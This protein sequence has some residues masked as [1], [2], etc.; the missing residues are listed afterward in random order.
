MP[1]EETNIYHITFL[2]HGESVGNAGGYHQG[3]SEFSLTEKGRQQAE[4]LAIRWKTEGIR[5]DFMISSPQSRAKETAEIIAATLGLEIEFDPVWM[6]RDNGQLAG[7]HESEAREK[8]PQ[9]DFIHLY[10]RI[11]ETGES[12]WELFLRGGRAIQSILHQPAGRYL[13]VSHGAILNMALRAALGIMPQ[14]NFQGARFRFSNTG[15]ATLVYQPERNSWVVLGINDH[16][17]WMEV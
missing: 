15:F 8:Y 12:H 16:S 9:P 1:A 3:Q 14:A 7:L 17:H 2:R 10:E 13:I 4:A 11:G 6:E 5:F